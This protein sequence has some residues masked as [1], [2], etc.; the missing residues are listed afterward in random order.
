MTPEHRTQILTKGRISKHKVW[1]RLFYVCSGLCETDNLNKAGY[2][3]V[4]LAALTAAESPDD[5]E[6]AQQLLKLGD[7]NVRSRQVRIQAAAAL[8]IKYMSNSLLWC[9]HGV[10]VDK[11][12][13]IN[14]KTN[15]WE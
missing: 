12:K 6:V 3:P 4:M 2:T 8:K 15:V 7:V 10:I 14:R 9:V 1:S 11:N 13:E 5:L